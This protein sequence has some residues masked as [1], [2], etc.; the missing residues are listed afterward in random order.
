MSE[1]NKCIVTSKFHNRLIHLNLISLIP[2][3]PRTA[4]AYIGILRTIWF[5]LEAKYIYYSWF[6]SFNTLYLYFKIESVL[7]E[8]QTAALPD[9]LLSDVLR[10]GAARPVAR[11]FERGSGLTVVRNLGS[12]GSSTVGETLRLAIGVRSI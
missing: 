12:W 1:T 3:A 6:F 9:L 10:T 8:N 5:I 2:Y 11:G 4:E 7:I